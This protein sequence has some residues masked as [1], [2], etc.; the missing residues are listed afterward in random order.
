MIC[1]LSGQWSTDFC[2]ICDCDKTNP[3]RV[4]PRPESEEPAADFCEPVEPT[5]WHHLRDVRLRQEGGH[6]D[7]R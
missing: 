1:P 5:Y 2:A 4:V 3:P 7:D 6:D